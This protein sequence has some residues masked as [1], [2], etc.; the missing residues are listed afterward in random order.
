MR[1][2][3]GSLALMLLQLLFFTSCIKEPAN[4]NPEISVITV[5]PV[6]VYAGGT[7]KV[8]VEATDPDNDA[9]SYSYRVSRG[10]IEGF[11]K[12]A[13]WSGAMSDG[14]DTVQI[15][16][17]DG[18]GGQVSAPAYVSVN[19]TTTLLTGGIRLPDNIS[20]NLLYSQVSIYADYDHWL[21]N[22]P[23][24]SITVGDE[25]SK[26]VF[27]MMG[28]VPGNYVLDVWKDADNNGRWS[29]GDYVGWFGSGSLGQPVFTPLQIVNG[30]TLVC[31]ITNMQ[32]VSF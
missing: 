19:G 6:E 2:F 13:F 9:L 7:A 11:G 16:I 29:Y 18:K 1:F 28:V 25:G 14:V 21:A 15:T 5:N 26:V 12:L 3:H 32:L 27:N 4:R 8:A 10:S 30:Q 17:T 23:A 31:S 22:D 20:G 24:Q